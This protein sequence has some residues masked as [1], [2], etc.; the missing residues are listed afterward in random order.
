MNGYRSRRYLSRG[1]LRDPIPSLL[2]SF[3]STDPSREGWKRKKRSTLKS[4]S[5]PARNNSREFRRESFGNF[6]SCIGR[7]WE[8]RIFARI[9]TRSVDDFMKNLNLRKPRVPSCGTKIY[10]CLIKRMGR[11]R[12]RRLVPP[13][14]FVTFPHF[15]IS[16]TACYVSSK[17]RSSSYYSGFIYMAVPFS[18]VSINIARFPRVC[19]V[20]MTRT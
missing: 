14:T 16:M 2:S 10:N 19:H 5:P 13:R 15:H 9:F 18:I 4:E 11:E 3:F 12:E 20:F 8:R 1:W 6:T 17:E 7:E